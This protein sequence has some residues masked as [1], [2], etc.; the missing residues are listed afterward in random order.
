MKKKDFKKLALLGIA[1]ALIASQGAAQADD[2]SDDN[3]NTE[4]LAGM[5]AAGCGA[6]GCSHSNS[7]PGSR[8]MIADADENTT[9]D[10]SSSQMLTEDQLMSQ[11]NDQG[12]QMYNN[13]TPEGK[14]LALKLASKNAFRDKNMA[15]KIAAQKQARDQTNTGSYSG[16]TSTGTFSP[17]NG[18]TSSG[19]FNQSS[20]GY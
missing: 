15:V 9:M 20:N 2:Q 1:G 4:I 19:S 16:Q 10:G 3:N 7:G 17:S 12:K 14:S 5:L 11:L 8:G 13:L 6:H 18:Q